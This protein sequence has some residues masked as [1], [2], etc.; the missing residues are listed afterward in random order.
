MNSFQ[1]NRR[2]RRKLVLVTVIVFLLVFSDFI[3][4]GLVRKSVRDTIGIFNGIIMKVAS[5]VSDSKPLASRKT[6]LDENK[7]LQEEIKELSSFKI[8][9]ELLRAENESL[10]KLLGLESGRNGGKTVRILSTLNSSPFST[11]VAG[12]G[13]G[14]GISVGDHVVIEDSIAIGFVSEVGKKT[15]LVTLFTAPSQK[16]QVILGGISV[17]MNGRG[18]GNAVVELPR[19]VEISE[20]DLVPLSGSEFVVGVVG[21]VESSPAD[22]FQNIYIYVPSSISSQSFVRIFWSI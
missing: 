17:E 15:S 19:D 20:G 22:A 5:T 21:R 6:L 4:D 2:S 16:T 7:K 13:E 1:Q 10:G 12:V 18:G 3:S 14:E 8:R 11:L 9:N